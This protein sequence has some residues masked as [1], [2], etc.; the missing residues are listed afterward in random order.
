MFIREILE[1]NSRL[2]PDKICLIDG[3]T[4]LSFRQLD[5]NVNRMANAFLKIGIQRHEKVGILLSNCKEYVEVLFALFK[6]AAIV[7]PLNCK[8]TKRELKEVINFSEIKTLLFGREFYHCIRSIQEDLACVENFLHV[9]TIAGDTLNIHEMMQKCST[10]APPIRGK[11]TNLALLMFTSGST[12]S[13]KGVM[14]ATENIMS[15]VNSLSLHLI[16][17]FG[18]VAL[19]IGHFSHISPIVALF[20]AYVIG[21]CVVILEDYN[22]PNSILDLIEREKVTY[23]DIPSPMINPLLQIVETRHYNCESLRCICYG[24][25]PI[26]VEVLKKALTLFRCDF[27]QGY[28]LTEATAVLT[29]LGPHDHVADEDDQRAK[30]LRSVGRE[31]YGCEV[32]VVNNG[33]E[34]QPGEIGEVVARGDSIM[35]GYYND[36][37]GTDE[38][39]KDGWLSTGDRATIDEHGYIYILD[40]EKDIIISAGENISAREVENILLLH[41]CVKEAAV[42]GVPDKKKTKKV[43]AFVVLKTGREVT[44]REIIDHCSSYL[45]PYKTP[46]EI[47]FLQVLPKSPMGKVKKEELGILP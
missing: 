28:G 38:C 22:N 12:G 29:L 17:Y 2:Y 34:V 41:P 20:I 36:P 4:R 19:P 26:S 7:V 24:T 1:R 35:R 6:C 40:R 18:E 42:V 13:P 14:L 21:A 8:F 16:P 23:L 10:E 33:K 31:I 44:K 30:R 43:K 5:E 32:R 3:E 46:K 11:E 47:E 9:G 15:N 27:I 39:L 37:G 45:A 25:S